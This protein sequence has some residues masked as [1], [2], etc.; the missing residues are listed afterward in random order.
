MFT[1]SRFS[2]TN[3]YKILPSLEMIW[4]GGISRL[5]LTLESKASFGRTSLIFAAQKTQPAITA[6]EEKMN[7]SNAKI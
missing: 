6:A 4:V 5:C 7:P 1:H 2:A 3:S